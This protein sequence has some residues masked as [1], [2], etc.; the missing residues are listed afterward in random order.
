MSEYGAGTTTSQATQESDESYKKI[1]PNKDHP[2]P[3]IGAGRLYFRITRPGADEIKHGMEFWLNAGFRRGSGDAISIPRVSPNPFSDFLVVNS[4]TN[5]RFVARSAADKGCPLSALADQGHPVVA[6]N[7][8]KT[9]D[10]TGKNK[11]NVDPFHAMCVQVVRPKRGAD[12]KVVMAEGKPVFDILPEE[13]VFKMRQAWWDQWVNLVEPKA[14]AEA[15][16]DGFTDAAAVKPKTFPTKDLSKVIWF[17]E[18]KRRTKNAT[19]NAKMDVDYVLDYSD[20]VFIQDADIPKDYVEIESLDKIFQAPTKEELAELVAK[21]EAHARGDAPAQA[22][23]G[24]QGG[25]AQGGG[26]AVAAGESVPAAG[27]PDPESPAGQG[28][29]AAPAAP[30]AAAPAAPAAGATEEEDHPF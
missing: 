26:E 8:F 12:G 29:G 1:I 25:G 2:I 13:M 6:L 18:K 15:Q 19:G 4:R 24:Q 10:K 28:A 5:A 16:D 7:R 17:I 14:E 9:D 3:D 22:G 30:A 11:P 23:G 27:A 20:K 21:A